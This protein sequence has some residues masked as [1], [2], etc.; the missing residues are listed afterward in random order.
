MPCS[1]R[2]SCARRFA[3]SG[4]VLVSA[5]ISR[6]A[7]AAMSSSQTASSAASL[8]SDSTTKRAARAT[9]VA[10]LNAVPPASASRR[11]ARAT[12]SLP[13][14]SKPAR[15]RLADIADPMMPSPTTPTALRAP[16]LPLSVFFTRS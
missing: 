10:L 1:A 5:T 7:A 16:A 2:R 3:A 11:R 4:S 8:G 13:N 9:S 12:G 14:S 15:T 6:L